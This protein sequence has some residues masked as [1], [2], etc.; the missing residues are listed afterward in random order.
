MQCSLHAS[1][2][3][4]LHRR[5]F[6]S[7][8][9]AAKGGA[10]FFVSLLHYVLPS[11]P[12]IT[13]QYYPSKLCSCF[14]ALA[15]SPSRSLVT[16]GS[17]T[18]CLA[19]PRYNKLLPRN[20]RDR[21][22]LMSGIDDL[23][24][25]L[26]TCCSCFCIG[27]NEASGLWC[28]YTSC[29]CR[30]RRAMD[31]NDFERTVEELYASNKG[32]EAGHDGTAHVVELQPRSGRGRH[33]EPSASS[34]SGSDPS[35]PAGANQPLQSTQPAPR[36]SMEAPPRRSADA[37]G[38]RERER[39]AGESRTERKERTREW[40]HAHSVSEPKM[41]PPADERA[42]ERS[43]SRSRQGEHRDEGRQRSQSHP[44]PGAART[45]QGSMRSRN[46]DRQVQ[47]QGQGQGHSQKPSDAQAYAHAV[48]RAWKRSEEDVREGDAGA[49]GQGRNRED[50][51][52]QDMSD[53]R[54][55]VGYTKIS[56][57]PPRLDI[58]ASLRPGRPDSWMDPAPAPA[59][60]KSLPLLPA[61]GDAQ[62]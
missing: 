31:D 25:C 21:P 39:A 33:G 56:A 17:I 36:P 23:C 34:P 28:F 24:A 13:R 45:P 38:D 60:S 61:A 51:R 59:Q 27:C 47:G 58:P 3:C 10:S 14:L 55:D 57:S 8:P 53:E 18:A 5:L 19:E 40:V 52:V 43:R 30:S 62:S 50:A 20:Q 42:R 29:S 1:T 12:L 35:A 41:Q 49:G 11:T 6:S 37:D 7:P 46:G 22:E 9:V 44:E 26:A 48:E 32:L 4:L 16:A 15:L 2:P 54:G